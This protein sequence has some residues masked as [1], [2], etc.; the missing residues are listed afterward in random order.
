MS[1]KVKLLILIILSFSVY[2]IY[3][4]NHTSDIKIVSLGD[5][6]SIGINSYGIKECSYLDYW[7]DDLEKKGIKV[8]INQEYS[9]KDLSIFQLL[10]VIKYNPKIKRVLT[11][12]HYVILNLGYNDLLYKLSIDNNM[13][14]TNNNL[15]L[16]SIENDYKEL[17]KEIKKYY[18]KEIIVIGYYPYH[19]D[20]Y[21]KMIGIRKL[22]Q[23][24]CSV[25][26]IEY[27]DTYHLLENSKL[28]FSNPNS[29]YPNKEG[30]Q[31]IAEQIITKTLEKK[32]RIWYSNNALNYYDK[33]L[34]WRKE[35]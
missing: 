18:K 4:R 11:E 32:D 17:I 35:R 16:K 8:E 15:I 31:K 25:E 5:G 10:E 33:F 26:N 12:A 22:N 34:S 14:E 7:K 27:I 2:F 9:K 28:Y 23:I 3:Q 29:Y 13:S 24:L 21:Y 6:L 20:N 1:R 19:K 30:Y